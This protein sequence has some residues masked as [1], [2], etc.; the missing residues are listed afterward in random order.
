MLES[1]NLVHPNIERYM[2]SLNFMKLCFVYIYAFSFY[3]K[4]FMKTLEH[5]LTGFSR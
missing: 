1:L 3:I 2:N 5:V 4:S